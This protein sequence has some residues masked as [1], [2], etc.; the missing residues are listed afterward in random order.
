MVGKKG[1]WPKRF[2]FDGG[3]GGQKRGGQYSPPKFIIQKV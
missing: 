1:G 3:G 2:D